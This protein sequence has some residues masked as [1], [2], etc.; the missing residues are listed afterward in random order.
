M[1]CC[2][3]CKIEKPLDEF[4]KNKKSKDG[5]GRW[6]KKCM[7][8]YKIIWN[9]NNP[10]YQK[11]NYIKTKDI[12]SESAKIYYLNN[13]EHILETTSNYR[14]NNRENIRKKD[15]EYRKTNK[16]KEYMNKRSRERQQTD[17]NYRFAGRIM[18][19]V[20]GV[21]NR[22]EFIDIWHDV[23][24]VYEM[25]DITYHID[26]KIPK[27]WFKSDTPSIV[28][29]N[30]NNLQVIDAVYNLSKYD[31]WADSVCIEYFNI[32]KPH[33]KKQYIKLLKQNT[34]Y[35]DNKTISN[36]INNL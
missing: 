33:I 13:K 11:N 23:M 29:N 2:G 16:R 32:A 4:S 14:N 35:N 12:R 1:K 26:H 15:K 27:S 17:V 9:K 24:F 22:K 25:Y 21:K 36:F 5:C 18:Q 34:N 19:H 20:H 28:V 3:K 8:E 7:N 31:K 6:C 10:D 30:I